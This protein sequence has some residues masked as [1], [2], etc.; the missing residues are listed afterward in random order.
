MNEYGISRI[1]AKQNLKPDEEGKQ[2]EKREE[3]GTVMYLNEGRDKK[4]RKTTKTKL[5][6]NPYDTESEE[7]AKVDENQKPEEKGLEESFNRS[8]EWKQVREQLKEQG[9]ERLKDKMDMD[10]DDEA[11]EPGPNQVGKKMTL[12]YFKLYGRAEPIRMALW[13]AKVQYEDMRIDLK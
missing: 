10:V 3:E 12:Y 7:S 13:I 1:E 5:G 6:Q 11:A 4:K 8:E 2:K 9:A